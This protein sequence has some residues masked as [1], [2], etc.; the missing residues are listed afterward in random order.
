MKCINLSWVWVE[1]KLVLTYISFLTI[2]YNTSQ[3]H[4]TYEG[5]L[6][7]YLLNEIFNPCEEAHVHV[8][9]QIELV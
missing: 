8:H 1:L 9:V 6:I 5:I 7:Q 3:G 4:R 2:V